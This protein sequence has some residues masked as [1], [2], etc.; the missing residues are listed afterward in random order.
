MMIAIG[1]SAEAKRTIWKA[2]K[3]RGS[4]IPCRFPIWLKGWHGGPPCKRAKPP[5]AGIPNNSPVCS[6]SRL[7]TSTCK[8]LLPLAL[9]RRVS[10]PWGSNSTAH[11]VQKPAESTPTSMPPAPENRLSARF[12][13][14]RA[15]A[16]GAENRQQLSH[17]TGDEVLGL[18]DRPAWPARLGEA[19]RTGCTGLVAAAGDRPAPGPPWPPPWAQP[20]AAHRDHGAPWPPTPPAPHRHP[21][22]SG[23]CGW[24]RW[25]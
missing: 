22:C 6:V 16:M 3:P 5:A 1:R 9:R 8:T 14:A 2:N 24:W 12:L 13:A 15:L 20:G 7:R 10:A 17:S 25:V 18:T 23:A 4:S 19:L 11:I 21:P